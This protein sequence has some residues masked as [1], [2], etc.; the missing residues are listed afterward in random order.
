MVIYYCFSENWE[1]DGF[2]SEDGK[3][4]ATWSCNDACWR[5][6]YMSPLF[7]ALGIDIIKS[8]EFEAELE[9]YCREL[10]E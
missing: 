5:Q 2:F 9:K 1:Q 10:Y 4:L 8:D 7:Q 6:E 3:L